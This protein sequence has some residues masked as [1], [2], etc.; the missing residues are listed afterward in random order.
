MSSTETTIALFGATGGTGSEI[1]ASALEQGYR[2]RIMVRTPS[3]VVPSEH[4]N[5][6][7]LEGDC[8][9]SLETIR[10]TLQGADYVINV[11]GGPVGIPKDYPVGVYSE[12]LR[13]LV[14]AMKEQSSIKVYLHQSGVLTPHPDG[15]QPWGMWL[16]DAT[17]GRY[18]LRIG[19]NTDEHNVEQKYLESVRD[20]LP[21]K[22]IC[23]RPGGLQKGEGGTKLAASDTSPCYTMVDFKDLGV[24]TLEA[25]K[26]ESLYGKYPYVIKA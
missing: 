25:L 3:K 8:T 19:P 5:L 26:D 23:T 2:V 4:P 22:F 15:S 18:V 12:F 6:T 16:L 17:F 9:G 1:L 24:W 7:V 11:V 10:E 20:D 14:G 21:F 13:V